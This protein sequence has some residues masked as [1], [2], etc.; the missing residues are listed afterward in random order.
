VRLARAGIRKLV[1]IAPGFSADCLETREEL[2]ME[3]R[4]AFLDAGGE[5]F[6]YVPCLNDSA[7]GL[8]VIETVV[9]RELQGWI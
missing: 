3:N 2:D 6:S 5:Q 1:M 9:R 7:A 4:Q 8:R